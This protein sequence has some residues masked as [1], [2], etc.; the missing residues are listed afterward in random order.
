MKKRKQKQMQRLLAA[1]QAEKCGQKCS[2]I[3][4]KNL[5]GQVWDLAIQSQ[6]TVNQI[7]THGETLRLCNRFFSK[8]IQRLEKRLTTDRI[9]DTLLNLLGGMIGGIVGVFMWILCIL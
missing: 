5:Q 6:Q 1:K 8:E 2:Q 7:K 3:E 9:G 4:L